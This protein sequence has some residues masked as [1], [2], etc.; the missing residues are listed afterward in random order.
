[1]RGE[2]ERHDLTH[3]RTRCLGQGSVVADGSEEFVLDL[4]LTWQFHYL[5]YLLL[6]AVEQQTSAIAAQV[7]NAVAAGGDPI[8]AGLVVE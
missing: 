7:D 8:G 6:L 2:D 1:M 4:Q 5:G 3:F